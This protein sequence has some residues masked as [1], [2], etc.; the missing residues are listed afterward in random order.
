MDINATSILSYQ[1]AQNQQNVGLA[2]LKQSAKQDQSTA[3]ILE[4]AVEAAGAADGS[5]GSQLDI[6]V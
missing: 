4:N 6:T 1:L 2:M 5:R 3:T